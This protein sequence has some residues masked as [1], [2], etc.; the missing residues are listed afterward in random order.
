[1]LNMSGTLHLLI[2]KYPSSVGGVHRVQQSPNLP[3]L[4]ASPNIKNGNITPF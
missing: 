4:E 3:W 2:N 1:M